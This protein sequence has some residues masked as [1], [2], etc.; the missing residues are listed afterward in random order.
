MSRLSNVFVGVAIG[1]FVSTAFAVPAAGQSLAVDTSRLQDSK[2][3][4][5][6]P[7][8]QARPAAQ[9]KAKWEIEGRGGLM[10]GYSPGGGVG[11][12]PDPGTSFVT[13]N[14]FASRQI[15]S[16]YFGDGALLFNQFNV[17]G[18]T[19][20][21]KI[22]PL[23]PVLN[24]SS[25]SRQAGGAIGVRVARTLTD[26]VSVEFDFDANLGSMALSDA[27][28]TAIQASSNSFRSAWQL[29]LGGFAGFSDSSTVTMSS[30]HGAQ[31]LVM[32][33]VSYDL[34]TKGRLRPFVTGGVG[35][36]IESEDDLVTVAGH[37]QFLSAGG[38][39]PKNESDTV[40]VHYTTGNAL[41]FVVGGGVKRDISA[42]AG[43][44]VD[45][46][47]FLSQ[48]PSQIS[49]SANP[50]VAPGSPSSVLAFGPAPGLQFS[51][52]AGFNSTLSGPA[53][54]DFQSFT[55]SGM[56]AQFVL[57]FGYFR[58]F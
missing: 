27:T 30:T 29:G 36:S 21:I 16:W 5:P 38:V 43:I 24:A 19:A 6:S 28:T 55:G 32:G 20:N 47:V 35:M 9:P 48:D 58:R 13:F 18:G 53:I 11:K 44:R 39:A 34:T 56:R 17:N 49:V 51:T 40:T 15:S 22:T 4:Q 37:Y 2:A 54:T 33:A 57:T 12:L 10:T 50:V 8:P 41:A 1:A 23:D 31:M 7:Q 45:A 3:G 46:R 25:T 26:R 42:R 14:G 52:L